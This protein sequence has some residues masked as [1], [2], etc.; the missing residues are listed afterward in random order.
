ML[1]TEN[2]FHR[3]QSVFVTKSVVFFFFFQSQVLVLSFHH[4]F[5]TVSLHGTG[6]PMSFCNGWAGALL[7]GREDHASL[8]GSRSGK[9]DILYENSTERAENTFCHEWHL[10]KPLYLLEVAVK[11]VLWSFEPSVAQRQRNRKPISYKIT[12]H[13]RERDVR[14]FFPNMFEGQVLEIS[15]LQKI[16]WKVQRKIN[17]NN[18]C[19]SFFK[20]YS[21]WMMMKMTMLSITLPSTIIKVGPGQD[22]VFWG[23]FLV[24]NNISQQSLH[25]YN[26]SETELS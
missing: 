1:T 11:A 8:R 23:N 6:P 15:S 5:K 26:L 21:K 7:E 12:G 4:P 22:V 17:P 10:E 3:L 20:G 16:C 18:N 14:T 2:W 25:T 9:R 19:A 24:Q 13:H